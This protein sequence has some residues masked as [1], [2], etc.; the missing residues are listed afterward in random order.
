MDVTII[1]MF[2]IDTMIYEQ[3]MPAC[4][5]LYDTGDQIDT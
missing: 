4:S 1:R 3:Q 5:F 2:F